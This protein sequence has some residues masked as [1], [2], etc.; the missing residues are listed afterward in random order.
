M[1]E[2]AIDPTEVEGEIDAASIDDSILD[3]ILEYAE[4]KEADGLRARH[5]PAPAPEEEIP[6]VEAEGV[7]EG[8]EEI[9]PAM[10]EKLIAELAG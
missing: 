3:E 4:G 7:A 1:D 9:D 10:L 6:G 2:L 8:D 5:A